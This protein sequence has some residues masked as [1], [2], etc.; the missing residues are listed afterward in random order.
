MNKWILAGIY[1]AP[2]AAFAVASSI[3]SP[4]LDEAPMFTAPIQKVSLDISGLWKD[5]EAA[6]PNTV[7][8]SGIRKAP[9]PEKIGQVKIAS[10]ISDDTNEVFEL[11]EVSATGPQAEAPLL[12]F[13][14]QS[15]Y[16][17]AAQ[18]LAPEAYELGNF[19]IARASA[20]SGD[21]PAFGGFSTGG[22]SAPSGVS[23]VS[24]GPSTSEIETQ[25]TTLEKQF[26]DTDQDTRLAVTSVPLPAG[27]PLLTG[28]LVL[29]GLLRRKQRG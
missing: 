18:S 24:A 27:L 4:K 28:G 20:V 11:N 12:E 19:G 22:S 23:A 25:L 26:D 16:Q 21:L 2:M 5:D 15:A 10:G 14:K 7:A 17:V 3:S 6:S 29:F 9:T 13:A 8:Q 1:S